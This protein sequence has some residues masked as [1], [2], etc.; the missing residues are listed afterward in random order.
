MYLIQKPKTLKHKL[1][2]VSPVVA[3]LVLIVVAI[4]GAIAVGLIMSRVATDT[5]NQANVG[6]VANGAQNQLLIGG[7]T[8][9]YPVDAAAV[10][11]FESTYHV[12]VINTQ[13]GSDAGM[14]GVLSGALNI[15]MASSINAVNNLYNAIVNNNVVGVTPV[16]VLLGG[17]GVVFGTTS[18]CTLTLPAATCVA[19]AKI[20]AAPLYDNSATPNAC[21]E[22]SR[23]ALASMYALG[24]FYIIPAGCAGN[25]LLAAGVTNVAAGNA[26]PF[27]AISRSDFGGTEDTACGYLKGV[28]TPVLSYTSGSGICGNSFNIGS[29]NLGVL[30]TTQACSAAQ[31]AGSK[32]CVGFFDLGF[33]EGKSA[34]AAATCASAAGSQPCNI[35]IAEVTTSETSPDA[36]QGT[37][38]PANTCTTASCYVLPGQ[39]TGS[40]DTFI[41]SALK[42]AATQNPQ[43]LQYSQTA[44]LNIFFPDPAAIQ[45]AT[46]STAPSTQSPTAHPPQSKSSTSA[47]SSTT[48]QRLTSPAR[49]TTAST[50]SHQRKECNE[51]PLFQ[52]FP[53]SFSFQQKARCSRPYYSPSQ[54][55]FFSTLN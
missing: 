52:G 42:T 36:L 5:G 7:S 12:N 51:N 40:V 48:V 27:T 3:T 24:T 41:K 43:T 4:V 22:I 19:G 13:G 54:N 18:V 20:L 34:Q 55:Q 21:L 50:T 47:S 45:Q 38:T 25:I 26:G 33:A 39:S 28:G 31:I 6:Q 29:G 46:H 9:V 17:S 2:A 30:T 49:A 10:P 23:P 1:H 32:G 8:T 15:G 11:V 44:S 16:P 37:S 14:Q 53:P 35:F